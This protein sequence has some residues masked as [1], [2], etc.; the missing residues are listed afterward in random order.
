MDGGVVVEHASKKMIILSRRR[1]GVEN[2]VL[3]TTFDRITPP[4]QFE[5]FTR[6]L[7]FKRLQQK[8]IVLICW[9]YSKCC[10]DWHLIASS[11]DSGAPS[12]F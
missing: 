4:S 2:G 10:I 3:V 6:S 11:W 5:R 9:V 12:F 8:L 7:S 1:L